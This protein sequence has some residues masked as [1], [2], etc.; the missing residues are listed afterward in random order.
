[1]GSGKPRSAARVAGHALLLLAAC[2]SGSGSTPPP[3]PPPSAGA[4]HLATG[5]SSV[6]EGAGEARITVVRT[7]GS[8]GAVSV[9][10]ATSDGTALAGADYQATLTTV[11]FADGDA[12]SK[13]VA[14]PVLD[15]AVHEPDEAFS[16]TLSVPGGGALLGSPGSA[17]VTI[18]DDDVPLAVAGRLNDTG[19]TGCANTDSLGLACGSATAGTDAF[20][21]QDGDLGRDVTAPGNADGRVGFSLLKLDASG[22]PLADQ[23]ASYA[24]G[25]WACVRDQVTG[26]TW[27]VRTDDDGLRGRQS[28]YSWYEERGVGDGGLPGV[29]G[30]GSCQGS[31]CD[32]S[33]YRGAVNTTSLCGFADWRLPTRAEAIGFL[34]YGATAGPLVESAFFP[35]AA[36]G[37]FWTGEPSP[38][39]GVWSVDLSTGET[40]SE[41]RS[42]ALHVRLVRG[43]SQE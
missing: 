21:R 2:T 42:A 28:T 20:P 36:S 31:R 27:E 34:D 11:T 5:A 23:A 19:V 38:L 22:V 37:R 13:V 30:R 4:L 24:S 1:M 8:S 7:G 40:R 12:T 17:T 18:L 39:L 26:L 33:G 16:V 32:T 35:D 29:P 10:L 9:T 15:D 6:G 43:G 25:P 41:A 3:P 14:I